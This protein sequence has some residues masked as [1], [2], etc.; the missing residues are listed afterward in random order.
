MHN[1][2][3]AQIIANLTGL[4]AGH[5][6]EANQQVSTAN[7]NGALITHYTS[8]SIFKAALDN[9]I[10]LAVDFIER[11]DARVLTEAELDA[12]YK[13][14]FVPEVTPEVVG[15]PVDV[16]PPADT[17]STTQEA[18]TT[19]PSPEVTEADTTQPQEV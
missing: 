16:I 15:E 2:L 1:I 8:D 3:L 14:N 11:D 5:K 4:A 19:E 6:G 9:F 10:A 7:E 18:A 13:P 12:L 17:T